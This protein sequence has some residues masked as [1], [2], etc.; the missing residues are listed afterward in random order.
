MSDFPDS[1]QIRN[2]LNRARTGL[3]LTT[4]AP[5]QPAELSVFIKYL[6]LDGLAT[7]EWRSVRQSGENVLDLRRQ[8]KALL[9]RLCSAPWPEDELSRALWPLGLSPSYY[10]RVLD[11]AQEA[12]LGERLAP[13]MCLSPD[14]MEAALPMPSL[15]Y[16]HAVVFAATT[17]FTHEFYPLAV[18]AYER[19]S[20]RHGRL[21]IQLLGVHVD[22]LDSDGAIRRSIL[23]DPER[24][25]LLE[26]DWDTPLRPN[27][28][29]FLCLGSRERALH[30]DLA[31]RFDCPQLNP[32]GPSARAD[33]KAATLTGWSALGLEVPRFLRLEQGDRAAAQR[34][35]NEYPE[36]VVKPNWGTEGLGVAYFDRSDPDLENELLAALEFC[37]RQGAAL[38]QERRD[39]VLFHH[40]ELGG[41]HTLVLRLNLVYDGRR[42][43]LA[44]GFAQIGT[45]HKQ[46]ASRRRGGRILS[47]AEALSHLVARCRPLN[48]VDGPDIKLWAELVSK[49]ERA[50]GLFDKLLLVGLDVLLDLDS[51]DRLVPV[52]LEANP[53]PAGLCH[54]RLL[55]GPPSREDRVG[56]GAELWEGVESLYG[57]AFVPMPKLPRDPFAT[58]ATP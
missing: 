40:P 57:G 54:S 51:N 24:N 30:G 50:A 25:C 29:Q 18:D 33:D 20:L 1:R 27:S 36:G 31:A 22:W 41:L 9:S 39:G 26:A 28:V 34:F 37:W 3:G 42:H 23:L 8:F 44:S 6:L 38:I 11:L 13:E 53:R 5:L 19:D 58:A 12:V 43:R 10:N 2:A 15:G 35:I 45:D 14:R 7:E 21:C 52:F 4:D 46:P 48:P 16:R 56:V 55:C 17:G 47:L 32:Y 49:A